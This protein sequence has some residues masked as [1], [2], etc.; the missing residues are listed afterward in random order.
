MLCKGQF[1]IDAT[2][3]I[4]VACSGGR[5]YHSLTRWLR[6]QGGNRLCIITCTLQ[7]NV[8]CPLGFIDGEDGEGNVME[9]VWCRDDEQCTGMEPVARTS[10]NRYNYNYNSM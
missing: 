2:C 10:S 6:T 5:S 7:S 8:Y 3:R 1:T 4:N 9:G